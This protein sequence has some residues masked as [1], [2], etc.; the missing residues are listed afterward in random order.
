MSEMRPFTVLSKKMV[1]RKPFCKVEE[2][3]VRLPNGEKGTWWVHRSNDAVVVVPLLFD[4]K[5]LLQ[6][7]YKHGAGGIL[8]EFPAGMVDDGETPKQAAKRELQEETGY[9][10]KR[11]VPIGTCFANPT[12]TAMRYHFFIAEECEQHHEPQQEPEEQIE[13]F[14][15]HSW[16]DAM[17]YLLEHGPCGT[18]TLTALLLATQ[19]LEGQKG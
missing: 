15:Q 11:L 13:P 9:A 14:V 7:S 2:Q 6:R 5:V 19:Y 8:P 10:P 12:S 3:V 1:L 16:A 17:A 18:A 4:G